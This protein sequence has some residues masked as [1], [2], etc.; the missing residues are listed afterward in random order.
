MHEYKAEVM[1]VI[2]GDSVWLR[3]DLGFRVKKEANFRFLGIDAPELRGEERAMGLTA[4]EH[5]EGLLPPGTEVLLHSSKPD[6]YGG[7]WLGTI[8]LRQKDGV[9]LNVNQHMVDEGFAVPYKP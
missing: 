7:R 8:F 2:D 5:L 4:K 3:A 1:R 9:L 6:K